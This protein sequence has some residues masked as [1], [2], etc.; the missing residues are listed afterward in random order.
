M[1]FT[2]RQKLLAIFCFFLLIASFIGIQSINRFKQLGK[3]I[4]VILRE[5][6]RSVIACQQMKEALER[7]DSGTLIL[8]LGYEQEARGLI[9]KNIV[10]FKTALKM[11]LNNL[12]L[13]KES[14]YANHLKSQFARYVEKLR[15]LTDQHAP[16]PHDIYLQTLFPLFH[17]IKDSA[18]SILKMNQENMNEANNR[19]RINASR[20]SR[21]MIIFMAG[22]FLMAVV[23]MFFSNR[24]ILKPI[25][26]LISSANDITAGNLNLVVKVEAMDE[27]G[28]LS[29]A[30]NIMVTRLRTLRRS[31]NSRL[32]RIQQATQESFKNLPEFITIIDPQGL[33]E[34]STDPARAHFGLTLGMRI[35]DTPYPALIA[36]FRSVIENKRIASKEYKGEVMQLFIDN[37]EKF[38]QPKAF[39]ILDSD[40]EL[41]GLI[42]I[43]EDVTLLRQSDDIKKDLF[44]TVSHQLKTPLTS[45][46]MA[47][48]LLL[49]EKIGSLNEK[50]ADLLVSAR[51]E[52]ERLFEIISDLL[53]ISR[54]ESGNIR[55]H[56]VPVSSYQLVADAVESFRSETR[57]KGI[58]LETNLPDELPEVAADQT[59]I[60][61]VLGNLLANAVKYTRV[62]GKIIVS[63]K[64]DGDNVL[65]FVADN[66][67]GI[68][69]EYHAKVFD[70]FF[71]IPGQTNPHGEGLGLTIAKEIMAAH[72]GEISFESTENK[73]TTFKFSLKQYECYSK[74]RG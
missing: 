65:F 72:D 51:D 10:H 2:L 24:W 42:L 20:A 59:R 34:V 47:I 58:M 70:K 3:S 18:D 61:H 69:K 17:D 8:L 4:D 44:S 60:S 1:H 22:A 57:D 29:E 68:P 46:R 19:A 9:A 52:S 5:N 7:I 55:M 56:I 28:R 67:T 45:I 38:F 6:Y 49:E 26:R 27:I 21:D 53:D 66:G 33:V 31:D 62:G 37:K 41:N 15:L 74:N 12:T 54:I 73:G 43:L 16:F 13:P 50:Q 35:T 36:L 71:R 39:P 40:K 32:L 48:H 64:T 25:Q 23:F 14:Q 63:A 11:E 30:F